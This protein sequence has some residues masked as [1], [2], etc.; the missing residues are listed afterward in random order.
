[1]YLSLIVSLMLVSPLEEKAKADPV[2]EDL[3]KMEGEW[4]FE[5]F[6]VEGKDSSGE[7]NIKGMKLIVKGDTRTVIIGDEVRTKS[8]FKID[9]KAN[10]KTI[11]VTIKEGNGEGETLLGLY[12][13]D[14]DTFTVC[15]AFIGG[16]RPQKLESKE[17]SKSV[18]QVLKRVKEK[19]EDK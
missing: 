3:A 5:K 8:T 9:P 11:D 14:G 7:E 4:T 15:L 6:I 1:M 12:E 2:K 18:L 17:D 19:K 10:P 13:I 16:E